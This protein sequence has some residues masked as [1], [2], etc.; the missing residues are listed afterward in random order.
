VGLFDTVTNW[1]IRG[2]FADGVEL[3][4][5]DGS[6]LTIFTGTEGKV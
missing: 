4:F 1:D 5:I 3:K 2:R 6:D